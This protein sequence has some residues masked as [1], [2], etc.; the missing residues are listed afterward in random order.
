MTWPDI[1]LPAPNVS[2]A[3]RPLSDQPASVPPLSGGCDAPYDA[4][5]EGG[6]ETIGSLDIDAWLGG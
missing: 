4:W 2:G 3:S 1:A 5:K 6:N